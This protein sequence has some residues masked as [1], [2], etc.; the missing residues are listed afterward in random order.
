M[1]YQCL[2]FSSLVAV[3]LSGCSEGSKIAPDLLANVQRNDQPLVPSVVTVRAKIEPDINNWEG[4]DDS[5]QRSLEEAINNANIFGQSTAKPYKIIANVLIASQA[6]VSFGNFKGK[7]EIQYTVLDG[8]NKQILDK[9]IY[10]EAGSDEWH[11][12]GAKRHRR[13]RAVN[14]SKNV[15]QFVE[16]LQQRLKQP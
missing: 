10:T 1:K 5:V 3:F 9:K 11:F 2:L 7:L 13:A 4:I 15:L 6:A 8:D 14:I 16:I 12:Y